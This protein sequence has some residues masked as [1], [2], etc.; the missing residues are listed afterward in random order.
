MT[1]RSLQEQIVEFIKSKDSELERFSNTELCYMIFSNF[2]Q[3]IEKRKRIPKHSAL[4]LT[5]FG[6]KALK[7]EYENYFFDLETQEVS[8][9]DLI[10]LCNMLTW[11]FY[12]N[13][14]RTQLFLFG[15]EDAMM[16]KLYSNNIKNFLEAMSR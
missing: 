1:A 12:L 8:S 13:R 3:T 15:T 16:L 5:D 10:K 11:P 9:I 6:F 2:S 4:K 14:N 7:D